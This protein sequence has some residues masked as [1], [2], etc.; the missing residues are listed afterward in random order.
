MNTWEN[1]VKTLDKENERQNGLWYQRAGIDCIPHDPYSASL[2]DIV[3]VA[4]LLN[5]RNDIIKYTANNRSLWDAYC[6]GLVDVI[7][8]AKSVSDMRDI[9]INV[10]T[11]VCK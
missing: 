4:Q 9:L 11:E 8:E 6:D 10:I 5:Y 3:K 2:M 1:V 7:L